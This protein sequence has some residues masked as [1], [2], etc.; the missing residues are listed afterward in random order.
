MTA[1]ADDAA[2]AATP[3][4][5]FAERFLSRQAAL[6]PM[7]ATYIGL[8][9]YNTELP[10]LS[11]DGLA[12]RDA[13]AEESLIELSALVP[14]DD[15]DRVTVLAMNERLV[16][17][18]Q[19]HEAG[20]D[21]SDLKN[22][23]SPV[24]SL[25]NVFDLMPTATSDDWAEIGIRLSA[26]PTAIA[27]YISSLRLAASHG[28]VR[29][30][31][32]IKACI[33]QCQDNLGPNG[34]FEQFIGTALGSAP[35]A[36]SPAAG[37][38]AAGSPV[39]GELPQSVRRAL[40]TGAAAAQDGYQQLT[41]FL[42]DELLGQAPDSD[43]VGRD[44][45]QLFSREFLGATIDLEE[46]YAWGIDELTR[47]SQLAIETARKVLPGASVAEAAA[48]L[49]SDPARKL[50]G[51]AALQAWMQET[52][53]EAV[54]ALADTHFDIPEPIRTLECRIAP[55]HTGAIY[56]TGPSEDFS[57]PGR[58]WWSVPAGVTDFSTWLERTTVYHEGVPG[59]HLQVAQTAYRR[60]LLNSWRRLASWTSGHGEGW[61]LYA[62]WLMADLGFMQDPGD[63]LGLLDGQSL[64][65]ARVVIDIGVHCGFE[66][67][68]EV[69]GGAWTYEKAWRLLSAHSMMPEP[70]RRFELDR[71]LGWPGQAP[72]YKIGER[73]WLGLR[74]DVKARDGDTFDLKTFH[75]NAL[76]IGS[77]GLDVLR[78]AVLD[79]L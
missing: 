51:T 36:G 31:R 72:S 19:L 40:S 15:V 27:G 61:A 33:L 66:A 10:D 7:M 67:P 25:R 60:E 3:I 71:Y 74:D 8:S 48:H 42:A 57:R 6:D 70:G 35:T 76:D 23:A 22:I 49:D 26:I 34:F 41:D 75:R 56:Y 52:S 46:T 65:A 39:A 29:P 5:E 69:G 68:G 32:Q 30:Q 54:A 9:G 17:Q 50:A 47:I 14:V 37:S 13:L 45:Y 59:H 24:Q 64:R 79:E 1:N 63:F 58:M 43:P 73:Y 16:L 2:R 21:L 20:V 55:T 77:V 62:E 38:P 4:D 11:P 53:D 12:A 78:A 44:R 28:D 18:R